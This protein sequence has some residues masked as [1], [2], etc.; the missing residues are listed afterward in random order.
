MPARFN[1]L[2][3]PVADTKRAAAFYTAAFD[4][5]FTDF[6]PSYAATT[7]GDTD[8]GLQADPAERTAA[9]LPVIQVDDVDATLAAVQSAGGVVTAPVFA[10]PGG[11][12]FHFRDPDG[13]ELAAMQPR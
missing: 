3:L 10:F 11:R 13:H 6:G 7:T 1:Y 8:V 9:P 2:E 12:R 5:A 4:C